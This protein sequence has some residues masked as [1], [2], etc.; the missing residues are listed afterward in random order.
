MRKTEN[1]DRNHKLRKEPENSNVT[2]AVK[3]NIEKERERNIY[4]SQCKREKKMKKDIGK[5]ERE[6]E[7]DYTKYLC[8]S[9]RKMTMN[10]LDE[11]E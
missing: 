5:L 10:R 9:V 1:N 3:L 4:R 6:R 2:T 11:C 7:R 8:I